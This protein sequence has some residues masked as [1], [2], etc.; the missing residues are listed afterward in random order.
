[1]IKT[2]RD[3]TEFQVGHSAAAH[4]IRDVT[5]GEKKSH[6]FS[7]YCFPIKMVPFPPKPLLVPLGGKGQ[8][9]ILYLSFVFLI[10]KIHLENRKWLNSSSGY[11]PTQISSPFQLL[12]SSKRCWEIFITELLHHL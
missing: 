5:L 11:F 12:C 2:S 8:E 1:M 3:L 4:L 10:G 7:L 6:P 9:F